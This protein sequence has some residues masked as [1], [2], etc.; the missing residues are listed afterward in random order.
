[1]KA[2]L[3][4]G[5]TGALIL[6]LGLAT[7][8]LRA[9]SPDI[10]LPLGILMLPGL[11][12]LIL[13]RSPGCGVA[14]A[15][16]LFPAAA[17]LQPVLEAWYRCTGIDGCMAFLTGRPTLV[18]VWI[19]ALGAWVLSQALPLGLKLHNDRRARLRRESLEAKR[20]ALVEEW[21]LQ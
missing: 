2:R 5:M 21:G 18:R 4:K 7:G 9:L 15:I 3:G 14:R 12:A 1:M 19:A 13:D 6:L 16:L 17:C 10:A 8:G 11:V 20:Q